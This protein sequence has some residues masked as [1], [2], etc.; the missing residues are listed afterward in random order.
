MGT[1]TTWHIW[2]VRVKQHC[3]CVAKHDQNHISHTITMLCVYM[4]V[5]V[6]VRMY[7][8]KHD[9]IVTKSLQCSVIDLWTAE[10]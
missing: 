5:C 10:I 8:A 3:H 7:V 2:L 9:H 1:H 4:C 6:C